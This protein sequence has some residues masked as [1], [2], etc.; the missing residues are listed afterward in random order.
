MNG[1]MSL[2][3][4]LSSLLH[5]TVPATL[6]QGEAL[7]GRVF[8]LGTDHLSFEALLQHEAGA[9]KASVSQTSDGHH[10][11]IFNAHWVGEGNAWRFHGAL[12]DGE[13]LAEGRAIALFQDYVRA[14]GVEARLKKPVRSAA[15]V[16]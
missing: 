8:D 6:E 10:V 1:R 12:S 7:W 9:L 11:D 16:P 14:L 3:K 4:A 15:M 13:P 2:S 5:V